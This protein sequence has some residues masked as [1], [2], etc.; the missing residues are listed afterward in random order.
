MV[1]SGRGAILAFCEGR[2]TGI[3]DH[4]NIDIV[5]KRSLDQGRTWGPLQVI[6]SKGFQTWGNPAPVADRNTGRVWL[7]FTLNNTRVLVTSSD[8]DGV[9]WAPPRE[10]TSDVKRPDWTW[11]ATGPGHAIQ[12]SSGRLLV[13]CDHRT[14]QGMFSHVIYSDDHG[15]TWKLGGVLDQGTDECMAVETG[16]NLIYLSMRNLYG[17][18]RRASAWSDD[19]GL[20]WSKVRIEEELIDPVCQ[21]SIIRVSAGDGR[22]KDRILFL[23]PASPKR[24]NLSIRVSDDEGKS[25]SAPRTIYRGPGA[26]SDLVVFPGPAAGAIYENGKLWPYSKISFARLSLE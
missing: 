10:I 20:V 12:L 4:G 25:W 11:Y 9:T 24:E 14:A 16:D 1:L 23:N 21:A 3:F 8:D 5:L 18:K 26:Y 7:L 15:R 6:Q 19:G 2:K 17:R 13:P 22:G